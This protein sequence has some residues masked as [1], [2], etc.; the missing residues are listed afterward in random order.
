MGAVLLI[1]GALI[2][3]VVPIPGAE[4]YQTQSVE[5]I[6]SVVFWILMGVL[7]SV[8]LGSGLHTFLLYTGPH[9]IRVATAAV[10]CNSLD[11]SARI[12]S[13]GIEL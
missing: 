4:A 6:E 7:S 10:A 2:S 13:Y 12:N 3:L 5:F 11:F 9:I 8:G 1:G